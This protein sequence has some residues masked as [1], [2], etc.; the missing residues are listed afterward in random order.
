MYGTI[1]TGSKYA[2]SYSVYITRNGKII[3]P[4]HDI[5]PLNNGTITV[6]NEIP[7]FENAKFE[8]SKSERMNPILQ[9]TK[10]GKPRFVPNIHF[11]KGYMWNYG[12]IPQTW[13]D[14]NEKDTLCGENGDN[15]PLDIIEIGERRKMIGEVY[16]AKV[17]GGLAL[18][19]DGECDWKIVVIDVKD[20]KS[21][22]VNNIEDV[23]RE[24]PGLLMKTKEWFRDYK[25]P[26]GNKK[27]IFAL[28]ERFIDWEEAMNVIVKG[29]ESWKKLFNKGDKEINLS[30]ASK[31][32]TLDINATNEPGNELPVDIE[33]FSYF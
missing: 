12:A 31:G 25:I 7:R 6:I 33:N 4:W 13:E 17:L 10:K 27:N 22:L 29:H 8:I 9:D 5:N 19:D 3:S 2:T 15:D 16:E 20:S 18:L 11:S 26:A 32:D 30:S 14:P 24:F 28:N 23:E 1:V 21:N